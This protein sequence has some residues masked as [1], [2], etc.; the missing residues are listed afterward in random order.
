M[1]RVVKL[2]RKA[3]EWQRLLETGHVLSQAEIAR[4][5]G[6]SRARVTEILSLFNLAPNIQKHA[7]PMTDTVGMPVV[8]E[9]SLRSIA[10]I[11]DPKWQMKDFEER[12]GPP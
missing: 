4:Q 1:P 9:R 6:L 7:L 2:L 3:I 8:T 12:E 5:E 10:G 11:E